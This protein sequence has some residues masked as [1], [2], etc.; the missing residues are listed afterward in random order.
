MASLHELENEAWAYSVI[1]V[2][3]GHFLPGKTIHLLK[4]FTAPAKSL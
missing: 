3:E 1:A 2:D 4:L